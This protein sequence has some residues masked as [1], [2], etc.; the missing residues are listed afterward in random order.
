MKELEKQLKE[1]KE[2]LPHVVGLKYRDEYLSL[3]KVS[4]IPFVHISI[5]IPVSILVIYLI[6]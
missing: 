2:N 1:N 4:F 6:L 3:P 5:L